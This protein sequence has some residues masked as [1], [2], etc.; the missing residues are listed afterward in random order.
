[1]HELPIACT[2]NAGEGA[3][4]VEQWRLLGRRAQLGAEFSEGTLAVTYRESA[5]AELTE[6]VRA[7]RSCCAFLDWSLE[8]SGGNAV[9]L[10]RG[11]EGAEP[12]LNR[13]AGV[14]GALRRG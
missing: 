8:E 3:A 4:R 13:L 6:L 5:L 14:F 10:I 7:E 2:L 1:M 9:L 12:E 11:G